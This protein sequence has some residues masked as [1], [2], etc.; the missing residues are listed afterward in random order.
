MRKYHNLIE[1]KPHAIVRDDQG[2]Y[3]GW[4]RVWRDGDDIVTCPYGTG[5]RLKPTSEITYYEG[6]KYLRTYTGEVA[7]SL[8]V[9]DANR[10]DFP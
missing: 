7:W 1:C 5:F 9:E 2:Y 6:R 4:L 8:L 3:T 10:R